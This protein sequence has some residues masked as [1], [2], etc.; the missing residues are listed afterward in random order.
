[1]PA[2]G[3]RSRCVLNGNC[4]S[5]PAKLDDGGMVMHQRD[6]GQRLPLPRAQRLL[7]K[8]A[9]GPRILSRHRLPRLGGEAPE[10][11]QV[12]LVL[13]DLEPI[14]RTVADERGLA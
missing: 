13:A 1:M 3:R 11:Q 4:C 10:D 14:S 8:S 6:V 12:K 2:S 7:I 9:G 5:F